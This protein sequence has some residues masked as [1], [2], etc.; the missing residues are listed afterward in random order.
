MNLVIKTFSSRHYKVDVDD[1]CSSAHALVGHWNNLQLTPE[2][3]V[4]NI[5]LLTFTIWLGKSSEKYQC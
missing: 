1:V 5:T 4:R 3:S 2:V